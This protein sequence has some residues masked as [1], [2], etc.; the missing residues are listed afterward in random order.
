MNNVLFIGPYRQA[1][2]WG[3][4]SR[5][6]IKAIASQENVSLSTY[7]IYYLDNIQ[8][9]DESISRYENNKI[10]HYDYLIQKGLPGNFFYNGRYKKNIAL[11]ELETSDWKHAINSIN[12]LNSM[13]EIWVPSNFEKQ[14]L[15]KAGVTKTIKTISQPL[16]IELIK[17]TTSKIPLPKIIENSYKFYFIGEHVHR[18]NI[19]DL[20]I[21]FNL[22]F[23]FTDDVSLIIKSSVPGQDGNNSRQ[24][25][26]NDINNIKNSMGTKGKFKKELVICDRMSYE[27]V[28]KLHNSCDC[29]VMPSYGEAFCRPAAEALVLGK[30]PIV[31]KNTGMSDFINDT[32]G[33]LVKSYKT[34]VFLNHRPLSNDYDFYNSNQSWYK[35]DIYD[36]IEKMQ[37]AYKNRKSE[38]MSHKA[39]A[40]IDSI[41]NFSYSSIGSKLC[42]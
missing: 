10:D 3:E 31:N 20:I 11:T 34:P 40:G 32:N 9:I 36:L 35:I 33:F 5:C 38:E 16:D 29:F 28:I 1:D 13:D 7:P 22:A 6:Y 26:E 12:N 25:I 39:Q 4:A 41:N 19:Q 18:K 21:A 27:D 8:N 23:N 42:I 37:Y 15:I 14:A 24:I 2:G 30:T 17:N